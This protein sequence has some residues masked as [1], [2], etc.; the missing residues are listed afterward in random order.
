MTI[1]NNRIRPADDVRIEIHD[2]EGKLVDAYQGSGYNT[3]EE[4]IMAAYEGAAHAPLDI[5]DYIFTVANLTDRTSARYRMNAHD[6]VR[7]LA[8]P[9]P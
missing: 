8:E 3:V 9:H 1:M 6:H 5:R 2:D 4:A 7:I